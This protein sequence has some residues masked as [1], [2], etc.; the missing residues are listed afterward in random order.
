MAVR[1]SHAHKHEPHMAHCPWVLQRSVQKA[2]TTLCSIP[3][4]PPPNTGSPRRPQL[5]QLTSNQPATELQ[6]PDMHLRH[7]DTEKHPP[8]GSS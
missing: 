8:G 3:L 7:A 2:R 1:R 6:P 4:N 5:S